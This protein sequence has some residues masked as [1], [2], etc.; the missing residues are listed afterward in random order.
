[1]PRVLALTTALLATGCLERK[2][3]D[4]PPPDP[5]KVRA[6][7]AA[8][9]EAEDAR[10]AQIDAAIA[11]PPRVADE[12]CP[13]SVRV[14]FVPALSDLQLAWPGEPAPSPGAD[15]G[16]Y[17]SSYLRLLGSSIEVLAPLAS[18]SPLDP[19]SGFD[20]ATVTL[21]VDQWTDPVL[22][23]EREGRFI[24]GQ[25]VGRV[26][27]WDPAVKAVVCAAPVAAHN[28]NVTLVDTIGERGVQ[29]DALS[30]V[31]IDLVNEGLRDGLAHLHAVARI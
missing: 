23:A 21:V 7:R 5:A 25:L 9:E 30:K 13:A 26:L 29:E 2:H 28:G 31:R 14:P 4:A 27:V 15:T 19:R 24:P 8:K 12:P 16:P 11:T 3:R 20:G 17:L 18:G 22:P 10:R 6:E 1:M